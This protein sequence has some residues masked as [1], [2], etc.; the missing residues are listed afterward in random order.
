MLPRRKIIESFEHHHI[1]PW[2]HSPLFS[3]VWLYWSFAI[4]SGVLKYNF[5]TV[6]RG[7]IS[8][9]FFLFLRFYWPLCLNCLN[10]IES[11]LAKDR[12]IVQDRTY[13][14]TLTP[15]HAILSRSLYLNF[16]IFFSELT[17]I[18]SAL[19]YLA[20]TPAKRIRLKWNYFQNSVIAYSF[21]FCLFQPLLVF[22]LSQ[23]CQKIWP[24]CKHVACKSPSY[25]YKVVTLSKLRRLEI[26]LVRAISV[27]TR[28]RHVHRCF[29]WN[30]FCQNEPGWMRFC[31]PGITASWQAWVKLVAAFS[32]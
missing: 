28:G 32:S 26:L 30:L 16:G 27:V 10:N 14:L 19:S 29:L 6:R 17:K 7:S 1:R 15:P 23:I 20:R 12:K 5:R 11:C 24:K 2:I 31:Q 9:S 25:R 22:S 21:F 3:P 13:Y 4:F 8:T 18:K